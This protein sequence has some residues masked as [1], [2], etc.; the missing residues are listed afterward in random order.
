M[1]VQT[2]R[3]KIGTRGS[4]LALAQAREARDRLCAAH[5]FDTEEIE[6]VAIATT[7]DVRRDRPL[8]E[9][10]G[11]GLFTKEIE[12]ALI[13]RTIDL[14]VHSMKDMPTVLPQGLMIG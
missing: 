11:K 5:G 9:L 3:L 12:E 7:G 6:I 8:A 1:D 4:R 14:A 2:A 13:A 10:G